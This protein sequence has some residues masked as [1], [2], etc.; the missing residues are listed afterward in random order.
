MRD[1]NTTDKNSCLHGA[2]C[3]KGEIINILACYVII[4]GHTWNKEKVAE[5]DKR[6]D[7]VE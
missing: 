3:S 5:R 4:N 6:R 2:Y 1:I 7:R